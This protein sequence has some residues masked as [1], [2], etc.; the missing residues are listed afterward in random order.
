MIDNFLISKVGAR[1]RA[2]D[3]Q[4]LMLL[5]LPAQGRGVCQAYLQDGTLLLLVLRGKHSLFS[6]FF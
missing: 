1:I 3:W 5:S 4:G 2:N 6:S